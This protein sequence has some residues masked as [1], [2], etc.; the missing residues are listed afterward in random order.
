MGLEAIKDLYTGILASNIVRTLFSAKNTGHM[1]GSEKN[2]ALCLMAS[3]IL[4]QVSLPISY[5]W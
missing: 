4:T 5:V 2:W 1:P 3:A